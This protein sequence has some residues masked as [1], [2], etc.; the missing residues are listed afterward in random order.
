MAVYESLKAAPTRPRKGVTVLAS[1]RRRRAALVSATLAV[2]AACALAA[3]SAPAAFASEP[4]PASEVR[5]LSSVKTTDRVFF[6]TIDDGNVRDQAAADYVRRGRLPVTTFLTM[7]AVQGNWQYFAKMSR[8]DSIQNHTM[9]HK[10]LSLSSTDLDYEICATQRL[11]GREFGQRPWLLR[12][13][14]GAGWMSP[15]GRTAEIRSV[16]GA[17][18][19]KRVVLWNVVVLSDSTVQFASTPYQPGDIVLLHYN[20]NL[21]HN[22]QTIVAAYKARGL[23]PAP[24]SRYLR[25]PVK[26]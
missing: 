24:L 22:L 25:P 19:I 4:I 12:P 5:V 16:A 26:R 15:Y 3:G 18:G 23:S 8:F 21:K 13:P 6:I 2:S 7:S 14:Y 17:C 10:A 9:T 20:S 11:F 1:V